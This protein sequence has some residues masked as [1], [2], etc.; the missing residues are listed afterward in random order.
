MSDIEPQQSESILPAPGKKEM[1]TSDL[2]DI[3]RRIAVDGYTIIKGLDVSTEATAK[4]ELLDLFQRLGTVVSYFDQPRIMD[5]KPQ[6]GFQPAS[7][8]GKGYFDFHTDVTFHDSPPELFGLLCLQDDEIGGDS[9]LADGYEVVNELADDNEALRNTLVN[10]PPP[11]HVKSGY[12]KQPILSRDTKRP[13]IR[14][15]SDLIETSSDEQRR[16]I[17]RFA[18]RVKANS[19]TLHLSK[20]ELLVVD[21]HRMLHGRTDIV[22]NPSK[23]HLLRIYANAQDSPNPVKKTVDVK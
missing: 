8:G 13:T 10:F 12:I 4:Q 14:F 7:S 23:R 2:E 22:A 5:V 17:D 6:E 9:I 20:G 21:N 19:R 15:R 1:G 18:E 11:S 16:L 3:K